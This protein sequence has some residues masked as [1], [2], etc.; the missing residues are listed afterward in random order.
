MNWSKQDQQK[1]DLIL[2]TVI[3]NWLDIW[4]R[5]DFKTAAF[6]WKNMLVVDIVVVVLVIVVKK[7]CNNTSNN[8]Q[9]DKVAITI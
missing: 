1:V 5:K 4:Y 9:G 8:P 7:Y 6:E 2:T 3:V